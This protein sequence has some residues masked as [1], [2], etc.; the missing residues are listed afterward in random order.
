[1]SRTMRLSTDKFSRESP[2]ITEVRSALAL[3]AEPSG[4]SYVILSR[5]DNFVQFSGE[6]LERGDGHRLWRA[7]DPSHA[8][9]VFE[10]FHAHATL[11]D[12]VSWTDVSHEIARPGGCWRVVLSLIA[13]G[14]LV[15]LVLWLAMR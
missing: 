1:M 8:A 4:V 13:V 11:P 14:A 12:V 3:T 9:D 7:M 2:S 5:G 10:A 6:L 15:A